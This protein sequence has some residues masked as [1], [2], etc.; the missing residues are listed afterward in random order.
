MNIKIKLHT[1]PTACVKLPKRIVINR[2]CLQST[3]RC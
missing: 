3:L 1:A 2:R